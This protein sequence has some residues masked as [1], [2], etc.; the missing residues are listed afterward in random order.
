MEVYNDLS[1][2]WSISTIKLP[3]DRAYHGAVEI[4]DNLYI[5]GGYAGA[6]VGFVDSLHCLNMSTMVWMEMSPMMT[7]RCFNATATL[8]G[9]LYALGGNDGSNR[10]QS[11]EMYDP[12]TNMWT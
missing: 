2:T 9:K 8:D 6:Q 4:E 7:K 11:V 1:S 10:L 3:N 12:K 5:A